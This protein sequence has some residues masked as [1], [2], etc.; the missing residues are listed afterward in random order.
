MEGFS[1]LECVPASA[2]PASAAPLVEPLEPESWEI[3]RAAQEPPSSEG[4]LCGARGPAD[5]RGAAPNFG[6][7]KSKGQQG[8]RA[9][10]SRD[11]VVSEP[12]QP[13]LS[14]GPES[15]PSDRSVSTASTC[16]SLA[17]SSQESDEVFSDLEEKS[18]GKKRVLRKTKSWKTFFTMVHWSLRR[19]SSWVQ[20]AGHEGNF[21]ASEKGQ[22]LKKFSPVE[23]TCLVELMGDV[24]HPF[25]PTYHGVVETN[26]EHYIQMDDLLCGLDMPSIMDC[27]MGTRTYLEEEVN[28]AGQ[29]PV[30]RRDL[31]QKMVKV[32]PLAPTAQEHG[33]AAVTKPRYMQWRESISSSA[34][35]GFRIEGVTMEGGVVQRDF[36]QTRTK[37]QIVE[38]FLTF[39]RSHV[40]VLSTYLARLESLR[41]ALKESIFFKTHEVIGSSLLFL[42]DRKGQASV[43]M[44]DF[45]KTRPTPANVQLSHNVAWTQGNHEDGYLL[46]LQNLI[47]TMQATLDKAK[48]HQE[49][50]AAFHS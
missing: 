20:L 32:D 9:P 44:I 36:K 47:D 19:R 41:Q 17:G 22:I 7:P 45:G 1:S 39:T 48:K 10:P 30:A 27:K 50:T 3:S 46:G 8:P 18:P 42:H 40:D 35:L 21:K 14:A 2:V 37:E 31:Y 13:V 6:T 34:T 15:L 12:P 25:V 23:N 28:K 24:L 43:W 49:E 38:T 29:S 26:G 4:S 16:S 5:G 33:Q 11:A